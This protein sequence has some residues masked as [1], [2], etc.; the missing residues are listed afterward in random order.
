M[1]A[2]H[3]NGGYR[4]W[5]RLVRFVPYGVA[6]WPGPLR[7]EFW[8]RSGPDEGR[9]DQLWLAHDDRAAGTDL[10]IGTFDL[11]DHS[12]DSYDLAFEAAIKL[13]NIGLPGPEVPRPEGFGTRLVGYA[14]QLAAARHRW[15][16]MPITVGDGASRLRYAQFAGCWAGTVDGYPIGLHSTGPYPRALTLVPVHD[17]A[18]YGFDRVAGVRFVDMQGPPSWSPGAHR[19]PDH[20]AVL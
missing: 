5:P 10:V 15:S 13:V 2:E 1:S 4:Y 6:G 3:G 16:T 19:H 8:Q 18:P 9:A 20:H 17:T 11:S 12:A 7:L 14:D